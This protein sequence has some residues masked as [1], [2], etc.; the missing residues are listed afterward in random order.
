MTYLSPNKAYAAYHMM[1]AL[2][3]NPG[4]CFAT[5]SCDTTCTHTHTS[6]LHIFSSTVTLLSVNIFSGFFFQ[7][8]S[9]YLPSNFLG[10]SSSHS[11]C[12]V[13]AMSCS[14]SLFFGFVPLRASLSVLESRFPARDPAD[15]CSQCK[16]TCCS[17]T[18]NH[19]GP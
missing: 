15:H 14:Q 8:A 18:T 10:S 16:H 6:A 12:C 17:C 7:Q 2:H 11:L 9:I 1:L 3:M 4:T 13:W 19:R 5:S